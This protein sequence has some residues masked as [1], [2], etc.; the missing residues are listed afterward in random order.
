M[1]AKHVQKT[2]WKYLTYAPAAAEVNAPQGHEGEKQKS[3][4]KINETETCAKNNIIKTKARKIIYLRRA[5]ETRKT[6]IICYAKDARDNS[7]TSFSYVGKTLNSY[8][9]SSPT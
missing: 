9:K 7:K 6:M 8:R 2:M 4:V 1:K 5:G 3:I